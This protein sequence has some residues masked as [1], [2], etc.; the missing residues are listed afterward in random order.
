MD[1][2]RRNLQKSYV[3][4]LLDVVISKVPGTTETDVYSLVKAELKGLQNNLKQAIPKTHDSLN[5]YHLMDLENR[6][7]KVINAKS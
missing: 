3:G 2:Y 6:I 5:K 1:T 4:A 7:S